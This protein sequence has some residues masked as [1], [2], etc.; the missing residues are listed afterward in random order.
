MKPVKRYYP[1][2]NPLPKVVVV[3]PYVTRK[4]K[5]VRAYRRKPQYR[6]GVIIGYK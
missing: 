4:G 3:R 2:V 5:V 6:T 1:S